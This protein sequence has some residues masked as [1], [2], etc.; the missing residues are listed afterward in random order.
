MNSAS[1]A[2]SFHHRGF[3]L[4]EARVRGASAAMGGGVG[5]GEYRG[6]WGRDAHPGAAFYAQ[7]SAAALMRQ[8]AQAE[9]GSLGRWLV[10]AQG[11]WMSHCPPAPLKQAPPAHLSRSAAQRSQPSARQRA[12]QCSRSRWQRLALPLLAQRPR[13]PGWGVGRKCLCGSSGSFNF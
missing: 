7:S 13:G 5:G 1:S 10:L 11:G 3:G 9:A 6:E 4:G 2:R 12:L 8:P